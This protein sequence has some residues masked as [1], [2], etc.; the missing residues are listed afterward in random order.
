MIRRGGVHER[1]P[2]HGLLKNAS[3]HDAEYL[4]RDALD[5]SS[6]ASSR[7]ATTAAAACRSARRSRRCS[8]R[9]T[10]HELR[11]GEARAGRDPRGHRPLLP[12]QALLQ[13]LPVS[14]AARV[15]DRLPEADVAREARAGAGRG[16]SARGARRRAAGPDGQDVVPDGV[17]HERGVQEPRGAPPDGEGHRHRP[18]LDHA[19]LRVSGRSRRSSQGH[20]HGVGR[21]RPRDPLHHLLRRVQRGRT[22]RAPRSRCSSTTA[23]RSRAATR[24]A[25][26]RR[27]CTAAISRA[28][29][30]TRRRSSPALIARV[31]EGVPGR[32]A[33]AD[34]LLPAEE[35]VSRAARHRRRARGRGRHARSRR[36]PVQARRREEADARVPE[37]ARPHRLPPALPPEGAEHRLPLAA[38]PGSGLRRRAHDRR[39]LRRRRHL[40]HEGALVGAEPEDRGQAGAW[41]SRAPSPSTSPPTARSRRCA[42]WSG[43]ASEAVHPVV[44]LHEA[45]GLG[46]A[47]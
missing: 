42:S 41:R 34:L 43:P 29:G 24:P 33:R 10:R 3:L 20:R 7:C 8:T 16:H 22:P 37:E 31:R 17:A 30:R 40:G 14:P 36:V 12:V 39:L 47:R 13:P 38:A 46:D 21:E 28:R 44:L 11:G 4:D 9:S 35:R 5:A 2:S 26:A 19:D 6:C 25:A 23:S 32:R 18:A 45:Y 27:S 15:G 1:R